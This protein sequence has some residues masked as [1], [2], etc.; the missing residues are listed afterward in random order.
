ME[1]DKDMLPGSG[2]IIAYLAIL[3]IILKT[4]GNEGV[5]LA[6]KRF[7]KRYFL[8]KHW[9]FSFKPHVND[10]VPLFLIT[11]PIPLYLFDPTDELI[12]G[13]YQIWIFFGILTYI[14]IHYTPLDVSAI[15]TE[16]VKV[17]RE[18]LK[19]L[20]IRLIKAYHPDRAKNE[21]DRAIREL[22]TKRINDAF[23]RGDE[24]TLKQILK[25]GRG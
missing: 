10:L 7:F 21:R 8:L 25:M 2:E 22:I 19:K 4:W 13:F 3:F 9:R 11:L 23:C 6:V 20:Y 16:K 5:D 18:G 17:N 14:I 24:F 1:Y 12:I 15:R